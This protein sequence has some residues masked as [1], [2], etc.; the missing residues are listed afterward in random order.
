MPSKQGGRGKKGKEAEWKERREREGARQTKGRLIRSR[1]KV[2]MERREKGTERENS[3]RER[4]R[5]RVRKPTTEKVRVRIKR[6]RV[7]ATGAVNNFNL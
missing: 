1:G 6:G 5:E 2:R 3:V 7:G 4:G